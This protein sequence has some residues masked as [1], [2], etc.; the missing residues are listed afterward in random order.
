M[1]RQNCSDIRQNLS[2]I[3]EGP[4]VS[5][6]VD[7]SSCVNLHNLFT[8]SSQE[9]EVGLST[10]LPTGLVTPHTNNRVVSTENNRC[11]NDG[12]ADILSVRENLFRESASPDI[13]VHD[14]LEDLE[15]EKELNVF[16]TEEFL[17]NNNHDRFSIEDQD[18]IPIG[19]FAQPM[20]LKEKMS[21][22]TSN[23]YIA[24][25][26]QSSGLFLRKKD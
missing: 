2:N 20:S 1:A 10:H 3:S 17:L 18:Q 16:D 15:T 7:R 4:N 22:I 14:D 19:R 5:S 8:N 21:S 9:S 6:R 26:V 13:N 12:N 11:E 24:E 23:R 25:R